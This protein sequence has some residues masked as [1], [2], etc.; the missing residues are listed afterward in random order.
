M[1]R[2]LPTPTVANQ[3]QYF[4]NFNYFSNSSTTNPSNPD[5]SKS[6]FNDP[7]F[8]VNPAEYF[9]LAVPGTQCSSSPPLDTLTGN[10]LYYSAANPWIGV[11]KTASYIPDAAGYAYTE[12]RYTDDPTQ[13]VSVQGGAGQAYQIGNGHTT[14][15]FYGQPAQNELDALFG[16]EAGDASHY[17]KNMVQDA[18]GQMSV[19]YVDMHGRTVA[20]ALAGGAPAQLASINTNTAFYPVASGLLT[21]S[22]L[23]QTANVISGDSI[24]STKTILVPA[25]TMYHFFYALNP[26]ILQETNCNRQNVCFDC[27]YNLEITIRKEGCANSTPIVLN[28]SNLQIIRADQACDS[29][30]GFIG[31]GISTPAKQIIDSVLLTAGSWVVRK[32]LTINDSVLQVREDSALSTFLCTTRQYLYDSVLNA[33]ETATS[34]KVPEAQR[35]C[36]ACAAVLSGYTTFRTNYLASLGDSVP[37]ESA[38][39]ALYT[40]DSLDCADACGMVNP[41]MTTLGQLRAELLNDM[42]AYTG[43]Y[44]LPLDS[45]SSTSL[46]QARYNIFETSYGG[47]LSPP[48]PS[49][50]FYQHPAAEPNGAGSYYMNNADSA[51]VTI[52]PLGQSG[53]VSELDTMSAGTFAELFDRNWAEQLIWY[54]P[55]YPKLRFAEDTLAA[56]FAWSDNLQLMNSYRTDSI[57]GYTNPLSSDPYFTYSSDAG[58]VPSDRTAM[59]GYLYTSLNPDTTTFSMW[60]VANGLAL[61]DSTQPLAVRQAFMATMSPSGI[62]PS[63]TDSVQKNAVWQAFRSEY[64]SYRNNMVMNY[65]NNQSATLSTAQMAELQ[66]E[67]KDPAF[68]YGQSDRGA[69]RVEQLVEYGNESFG[70]ELG[71]AAGFG[72]RLYRQQ[73][74]AAGSVYGPAAILAGAVDGMC[75]VAAVSAE[76]RSQRYRPGEH[77]HRQHTGSDGDGVSF[78]DQR[79]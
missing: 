69:K 17:F 63:A 72:K 14:N 26:A 28:Y 22:L 47:I 31:T 37:V 65:I 32:T 76:R 16:T 21:D 33:M 12:T 73:W 20:T 52:Y 59:N 79:Q 48:V 5:P 6:D 36:N 38:I 49:M 55:E 18:N 77:D 27:K 35:D 3:I 66:H 60:Q 50:P 44:A 71:G 1:C 4:H 51:D 70:R 75:A 11:E 24:Q 68:H 30:A 57:L 40:Q 42:V 25:N 34:C 54:H 19:T 8:Q 10:G 7:A 53:N 61:G 2:Y 56:V 15:Y 78:V 58:Y 62:D 45:I 67:G 39:H 64:L 29:S 46:L 74:G 41:A 43:Q 9:D 13:R 23:T